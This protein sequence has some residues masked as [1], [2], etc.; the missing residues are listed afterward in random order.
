MEDKG[1]YILV[2]EIPKACNIATGSIG[3]VDVNPGYY[4]YAGSG[5]NGLSSRISRHLRKKKAAL[6]CRFPSPGGR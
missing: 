5:M 4:L 2:M 1:A 3:R 6:A